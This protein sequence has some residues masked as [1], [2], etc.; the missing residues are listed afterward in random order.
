MYTWLYSIDVFCL[1]IFILTLSSRTTEFLNILTDNTTI[2]KQQNRKQILQILEALHIR[3]KSPKLNKIN[4]ESI[5]NELKCLLL[6]LLFIEP[7][8]K[9]NATT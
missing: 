1:H 2:F 7:N 5:T 8:L 4:F 9:T 3:N 6:L